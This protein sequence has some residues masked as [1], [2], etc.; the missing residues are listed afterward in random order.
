MDHD[1]DT[2][3]PVCFSIRCATCPDCGDFVC[4]CQCDPDTPPCEME[5]EQC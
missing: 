5:D 2:T 4:L 3:C 1:S